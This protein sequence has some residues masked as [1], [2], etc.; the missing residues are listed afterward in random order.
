MPSAI[1]AYLGVYV[2]RKMASYEKNNKS[3][4]WSVRF[5]LD[6][7]GKLKNMRLSGYPTKKAAQT[8]YVEF[9][10]N[11]VPPD[12]PI[13]DDKDPTFA[14]MAEEYLRFGRQ[15][16]KSSSYYGI[17][18]KVDNLILPFFGNVRMRQLSPAM[19]LEW[20]ESVAM[21]SYKYKTS[22]RTQ[23]NAICKYA[24]KYHDIPDVSSKAD[25]FRRIEPRKEMQIYTPEQFAK[26]CEAVDDSMM[27]VLFRTLY[28]SGCRKGELSALTWD[29][30]DPVRS[31][32]KINKSVIRKASGK[33]WEIST[34]KNQSSNRTIRMPSDLL[35][36][37]LSLRND[38]PGNYY[39]FGGERPLSDNRINRALAKY[40]DKAGLPRI[41]VHDFR[42]S[43]ASYLI[44]CG[45]SIVAVS[46]RLGH[47]NIQQTLNTYSHMM[48]QDED[49]IDAA[50]KKI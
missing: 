10:A 6:E 50:F 25:G 34:T 37:I 27:R 21:Y 12:K 9:M 7:G 14:E 2:K 8:A 39:V 46:K 33:T 16:W 23:V 26:F 15:R 28:V 18:K 30:I 40:A 3:G 29:D 38:A 1:I 5:R 48:P 19:I 47:A 17:K 42:H 11:Y 44:S 41:R 24:Y 35:G 13:T 22:M 31:A 4:K 43:C 20:Q 45:V 36:D 32:I 49:K